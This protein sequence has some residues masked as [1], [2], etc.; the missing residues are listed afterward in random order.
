MLLLAKR[1]EDEPEDH[2]DV[3]LVGDTDY[4]FGETIERLQTFD[5]SWVIPPFRRSDSAWSS[6]V[7]NNFS[8]HLPNHK[9]GGQ[10]CGV[11]K[12]AVKEYVRYLR[13][14]GYPVYWH[15]LNGITSRGRVIYEM[16]IE[17]FAFTTPVLLEGQCSDDLDEWPF[18]EWHEVRL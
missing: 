10:V 18:L 14:S 7:L 15:T 1:L 16:E 12:R 6:K 17:K 8:K 2:P 11:S 4:D 9:V 13:D 5:S 3:L